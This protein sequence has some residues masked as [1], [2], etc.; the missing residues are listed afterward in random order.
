MTERLRVLVCGDRDWNDWETITAELQRLPRDTVI[1][2]GGARGADKMAAYVAATDLCLSVIPFPADWKKH[3]KA[4]GPIRNQEMLDSGR[5][6]RVLAFH[7][8]LRNSKGTADM[9]R[10]ARAAGIPVR[11]VGD[12]EGGDEWPK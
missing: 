7:P 8:D 3:G 2:H 11:V 4:A 12:P 1:I 6:T 10:R 9:I 5:P